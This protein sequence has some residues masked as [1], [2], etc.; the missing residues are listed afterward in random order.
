MKAGCGYSI[1]IKLNKQ[2]FPLFKVV[3]TFESA[4]AHEILKCGHSRESF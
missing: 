1:Q 2:Y 3:L 4:P